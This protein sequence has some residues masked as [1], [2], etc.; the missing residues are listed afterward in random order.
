MFEV[1]RE[2]DAE[3]LIYSGIIFASLVA[4]TIIYGFG[5]RLYNKLYSKEEENLIPYT[6]KK[7]VNNTRNSDS[8]ED[9]VINKKIN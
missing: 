9:K 1:D 4:T 3:V 6:T 2:N 8:L 5:C 7:I